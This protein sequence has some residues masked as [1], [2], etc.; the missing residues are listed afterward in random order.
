MS[1]PSFHSP[2]ADFCH[3]EVGSTSHGLIIA[4]GRL[5][6]YRP[7]HHGGVLLIRDGMVTEVAA[8]S[9]RCITIPLSNSCRLVSFT[10]WMD[11]SVYSGY[12]DGYLLPIQAPMET[13]HSSTWLPSPQVQT[14]H[15]ETAVEADLLYHFGIS[16]RRSGNIVIS[17]YYVKL[18]GI[19]LLSLLWLVPRPL[20]P[21]HLGPCKCA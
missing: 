20:S 5:V 8:C 2:T 6:G 10:V 21:P 18:V 12:G 1:T 3:D 7:A 9:R 19:L 11:N 16:I 4:G 15:R 14:L 13:W 17:K